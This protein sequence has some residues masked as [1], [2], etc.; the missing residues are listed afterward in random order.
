MNRDCLFFFQTA[1]T[2]CEWEQG[3]INQELNLPISNHLGSIPL[4]K[5]VDPAMESEH[6]S[7]K[8]DPPGPLEVGRICYMLYGTGGFWRSWIPNSLTAGHKTL[9]VQSRVPG[10]P[11]PSSWSRK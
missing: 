9:V 6:Q 8:V 2:K 10:I 5:P 3:G 1:P 11:L 4:V 7:F